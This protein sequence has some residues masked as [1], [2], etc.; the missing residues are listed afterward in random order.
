MPTPPLSDELK[1]EAVEAVKEHGS[2]A[3]AARA[4]NVN[5]D[6]LDHR[7]RKGLEDPAIQA[8][9][10][11]VG[12]NLTPSMAWVK[13][14]AKDGEPGYSVMLKPAQGAD[15]ILERIRDAVDGITPVKP[16]P[17][18]DVIPGN[19]LNVIPIADAHVGMLAWKDETGEA[20]NTAKAVDRIKSW[21][22]Q[23][24]EAAPLA[25]TAVILDVGDLLHA[26]DQTNQTPRS[27]HALD[28]DTRHFRTLDLTIAAMA[29]AIETAL[30]RH[31][32]VV[33]RILPGNHDMHSH[34]AVMFALAERYRDEPRVDVQKQPG[35]FFV[36]EFG[37]VLIAAHH[38]DKS[39]PERI[40]MYL[41]DEHCEAWGRTRHRFLLTGHLHH[42]R[43]AD[44]GGVMW[45]QLRAVTPKDAYAASHA[46]V[47]RSQMQCITFDRDRGEIGRVKVSS[48]I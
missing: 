26:D 14:P 21:V 28:V 36:Y 16:T 9:M 35:E 3:A 5:R 45:E 43:S 33:V 17:P 8:S 32:K 11:A 30:T 40:V 29:S 34:M 19:L 15:D 20:Y 39:K 18:P 25:D 48:A 1:R 23:C 42:G 38:G 46:Y 12:T 6:T 22:A 4:L 41:A 13:V 2:V 24:V 37:K 47:A 27:K 10:D 44:I 7:Y 31:L